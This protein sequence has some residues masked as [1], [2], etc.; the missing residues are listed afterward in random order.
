VAAFVVLSVLAN[1]F[2]IAIVGKNASQSMHLSEKVDEQSFLAPKRSAGKRLKAESQPSLGET[3]LQKNGK[4]SLPKQKQV[5]PDEREQ[6]HVVFST[7]CSLEQDWQSYLFFFHAMIQKQQGTVTRI[8]SGC[9]SEQ[10]VEMSRIHQEQIVIMNERFNLHFTPDFGR[11]EGVSWHQTKYWNKPFGVKHW[12]ENKLGYRYEG[13]I[14]TPYD[15]DIIILVD[16]DMLMQRPFVNDFSNFPNNIW[17]S[18]FNNQP[19][20]LYHKVSHGHPMAQDYSFHDAWLR[21]GRD[22]LTHV[23]GP[24]SPVHNVS[25]LEARIFYPAGPPYILTARDM[26]RVVYHWTDFLPRLFKLFK[27]FMAEMYG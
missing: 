18:H 23:V 21:A 7:S 15:D 9:S 14:S 3:K 25:M 8:V 10:E 24:D 20:Q 16:P 19:D 13:N 4:V 2:N 27:G 12:L 5:S 26:Y 22:N 17:Q 1:F 6:Y 11:V